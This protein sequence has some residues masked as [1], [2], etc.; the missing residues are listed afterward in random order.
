M[1]DFDANRL[2]ASASI[3]SGVSRELL[4]D[5][6]LNQIGVYGLLSGRLTPGDEYSTL[7]CYIDAMIKYA[8]GNWQLGINAIIDDFT[9]S[10]SLAR[11]AFTVAELLGMDP[12]FADG[13][14][15]D[16]AKLSELM[17]RIR[18]LGF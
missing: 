9:R 1:L 5:A 4:S 10:Y 11:F 8:S 6:Y 15:L 16:P 17:D 3:R 12:T 13:V 2:V 14:E 7:L 18:P